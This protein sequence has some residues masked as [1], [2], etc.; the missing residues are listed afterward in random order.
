MEGSLYSGTS[1]P[2]RADGEGAVIGCMPCGGPLRALQRRPYK[3]ARGTCTGRSL[4]R[5]LRSATGWF[6]TT[7]KLCIAH[8]STRA[9][10]PLN[11]GASSAASLVSERPQMR[12]RAIV[13]VGVLADSAALFE[14]V[15]DVQDPRSAGGR[16]VVGGVTVPLEHAHSVDVD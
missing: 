13:N 10:E 5:Y 8:R 2:Q 15:V 4:L 16:I 3:P 6:R 14:H 11:I 12:E 9:P 7:A 1:S